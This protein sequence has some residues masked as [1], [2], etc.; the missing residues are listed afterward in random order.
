MDRNYQGAIGTWFDAWSDSEL[1]D[2][3]RRRIID[4]YDG[5]IHFADSLVGRVLDTIEELVVHE[6]TVIVITSDHGEEL[7]ERG[8]MGHGHSLHDELLRVPLII[9]WPG[10][11]PRARIEDQVR[12]MDL[13]PTLLDTL[14]LPVP[15]GLDGVSLMPL[16]R[17]SP[18]SA[19]RSKSVPAFVA[20][21]RMN[22]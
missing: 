21:V 15:P 16:A 20:S 3:D 18:G 6:R 7:F 2:A 8:T 12:T 5:E 19:R 11:T 17:V 1:S 4:L 9:R 14:A 22:F 10:G 13:F